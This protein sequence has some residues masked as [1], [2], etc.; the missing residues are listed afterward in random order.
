MALTDT[1]VKQ[2]KHTGKPTGDKH[3]D[4]GGMY[5]LVSATGKYWRMDYR[6]AGKRKTLS[7]GIYPTVGLAVARKRREEAKEQ[8]ENEIDPSQEKR[9]AKLIAAT[10][11]A[12]TL[13]AVAKE[14]LENNRSNWS[15]THAV[16][17]ARNIRKDL[18]PWLGKRP[19]GDITPPELLAVIRK[20]EDRGALDVA[21]RVLITSRGIWYHAIATGRAERNIT[22]DIGKALKPHLRK[23]F[24]ALVNPKDVGE[25]MR[26][27]YAYRGGPVVRAALQL[28]PILFQRPG[29]LRTMRWEDLNLEKPR[30][31]W[32]IP[33]EDMK[34]KKAEKVNGQPHQV[35]LPTQAIEIIEGLRPLTGDGEWVF[36]G[37]RNHK[38]PMSEASI[39]SALAAMGYKGRQSWHGFRAT[40]RTMIRQELGFKNVDAIEAQLAH[41]GQITHSGAYDRATHVEERMDML[42]IWADYLDKLRLG[43]DVIPIRAA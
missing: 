26:A 17:E 35:P 34:R 15:E 24:P 43:A 28:A 2:V 42:Q 21:H 25:L 23:N 20:V 27:I 8:L 5:L 38:I 3:R 12:N 6:F 16:R 36:P 33:S 37:F 4:G 10:A 30:E 40:G 19:I 41:K 18:V 11:G 29:N 9:Q 39:T 13:E 14:W 22:L 1:F 31:I 32:S 7:F